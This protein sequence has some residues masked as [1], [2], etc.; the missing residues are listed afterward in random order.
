ML[1][2]PAKVTVNKGYKVWTVGDDISWMRKGPDGRLYGQ[3]ILKTVS[4]A[5]RRVPTKNP[6]Q[7]RWQPFKKDTIY[8]QCL[9]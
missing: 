9:R 7:M 1:I 3:S 8:H 5:L 2:P 6:I 4:L